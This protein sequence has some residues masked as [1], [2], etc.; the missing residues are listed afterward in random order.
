MIAT[1]EERVFW[2]QE[3]FGG[4][5]LRGKRSFSE[6]IPPGSDPHVSVIKLS[7]SEGTSNGIAFVF[8]FESSSIPRSSIRAAGD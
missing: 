4:T 1:G 3:S 2:N 8:D 6:L 7:G 5:S